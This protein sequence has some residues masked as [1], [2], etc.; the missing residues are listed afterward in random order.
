MHLPC[1]LPTAQWLIFYVVFPGD[2]GPVTHGVSQERTRARNQKLLSAVHLPGPGLGDFVLE[3]SVWLCWV[4]IKKVTL[5]HLHSN[6]CE[7]K[8]GEYPLLTNYMPGTTGASTRALSCCFMTKT[9]R[10]S[11][12]M[13]VP[14][15]QSWHQPQESILSLFGCIICNSFFPQP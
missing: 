14:R 12:Q 2:W 1:C 7:Q 13:T 8:G 11:G 6:G 5:M 10:V 4:H 3:R 15:S 9:L